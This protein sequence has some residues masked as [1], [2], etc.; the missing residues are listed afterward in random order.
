MESAEN[1]LKGLFIR[2]LPSL[3]Q[4]R[5]STASITSKK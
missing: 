5:K 4:R 3:N 1:E 2:N